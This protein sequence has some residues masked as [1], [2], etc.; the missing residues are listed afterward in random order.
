MLGLNLNLVIDFRGVALMRVDDDWSSAK[1][2]LEVVD[3]VHVIIWNV[4]KPKFALN[5]SADQQQVTTCE[6]E[7]DWWSAMWKLEP[8][9][10][11]E[12]M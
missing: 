12:V 9:S 10:E 11:D 3:D 6:I 7:R 2:R 8:L 4:W 5:L 1:W